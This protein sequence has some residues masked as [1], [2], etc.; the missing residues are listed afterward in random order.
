MRKPEKQVTQEDM[1]KILERHTGAPIQRKSSLVGESP[2]EKLREPLK[3]GEPV[4]TG[5]LSGYVLTACGRYSI[6]KDVGVGDFITYTAWRVRM[7]SYEQPVLLG[8][9]TSRIEAERIAQADA[10]RGTA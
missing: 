9:R 10:D 2:K 4:R 3:W 7:S 6:S 5:R 8:C 1:W